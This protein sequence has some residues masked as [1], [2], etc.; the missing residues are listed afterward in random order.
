MN[1]A[2]ESFAGLDFNDA[3]IVVAINVEKRV[4][5]VDF[6][7]AVDAVGQ[8]YVDGLFRVLRWE[9][10][11]VETADRES[12]VQIDPIR[13]PAP[14]FIFE[15]ETIGEALILHG[16]TD[17]PKATNW[18]FA[19]FSDFQLSITRRSV[20]RAQD[21]GARKVEVALRDEPPKDEFAQSCVMVE[22]PHRGKA[23][24]ERDYA[25]RCLRDSQKR[26][27]FAFIPSALAA[28]LVAEEGEK[29]WGQVVEQ[30]HAAWSR[31][32]DASVFYTDIG[33]T[34]RMRDDMIRA[35]REGRPVRFRRI[36]E[37]DEA[38]RFIESH[39]TDM[40]AE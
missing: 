20:W 32:A 13:P 25:R 22:T 26:G 6:E 2:L 1:T 27:E 9:H 3:K 14:D 33:E 29:E 34:Q 28:Q 35:V 38:Q 10:L 21:T 5:Q 16:L 19:G 8:G 15:H 24:L 11:L 23:E 17:E 39:N 37:P 4:F 30:S 7:S 31:A 12:H 18:K 40:S 36:F